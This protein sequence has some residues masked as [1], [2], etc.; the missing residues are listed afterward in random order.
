MGTRRPPYFGMFG[1]LFMAYLSE[2]EVDRVLAK[3]PLAALTRSSI[4]DPF[5]FRERL[6]RIREQGYVIEQG[7]A[8][9]GIAGIAA[10]IRDSSGDMVAAV[11]VSFISVSVED[12]NLPRTLGE[13]LKTAHVISRVLGYVKGDLVDWDADASWE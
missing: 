3:Q 7:E 1:Q 4:T 12:K 11:G 10:P 8:I 2:D 13:V 5:E 6:A 9:D